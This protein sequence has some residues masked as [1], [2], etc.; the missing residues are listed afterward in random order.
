MIDGQGSLF[1]TAINTIKSIP[2]DV[3]WTYG[4]GTEIANA[5]DVAA[6]AVANVNANVAIDIF[7]DADVKKAVNNSAASHEV[8]VWLC[9]IG[10]A[11]QPIGYPNSITTATVNGTTFNLYFGTNGNGQSVLTWLA[12]TTIERFIGDIG[13][14]VTQVTQL[15]RPGVPAATDFIGYMGMGSEAYWT[16]QKVTFDV[17]YL[18]MDIKK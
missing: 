2:V 14:L 13:P 15:N 10:S 12:E 5:T 17:S 8:M 7:L 4:L 16:P 3:E 11:A 9:K 18:S 6:M 1:P